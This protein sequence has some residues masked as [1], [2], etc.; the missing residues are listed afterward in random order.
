MVL[1]DSPW[2]KKSDDDV[3]A[4]SIIWLYV[5][6][7]FSCFI[8]LISGYEVI[9]LFMMLRSTDAGVCKYHLTIKLT[10]ML[11]DSRDGQIRIINKRD[12]YVRSPAECKT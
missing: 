7:M 4:Q 1:D 5:Y 10:D 3:R 12:A 6:R 8:Y 2:D 11:V 9:S